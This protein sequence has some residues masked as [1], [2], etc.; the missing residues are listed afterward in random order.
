MLVQA[1]NIRIIQR[2]VFLMLRE[3][4]RL[5]LAILEIQRHIVFVQLHGADL[6][7]RP[8]IKQI[9][10]KLIAQ[11]VLDAQRFLLSAVIE[12]R[13]IADLR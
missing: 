3:D 5:A 6:I 9:L 4:D 11:H 8:A 7:L 2:D 12:D 10:L 1:G 13:G